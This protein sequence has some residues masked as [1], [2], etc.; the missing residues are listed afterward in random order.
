MPSGYQSPRAYNPSAN[1]FRQETEYH[2][3][4]SQPFPSPGY[5]SLDYNKTDEGENYDRMIAQDS[6]LKVRIRILRLF[7]RFLSVLLSAYT[8]ATMIQTL[9]K[10]YSTRHTL[11]EVSTPTGPVTRGPWALQTKTWPTYLLLVT[12]IITFFGSLIVVAFY[13]KGFK[14][15]NRAN[16]SVTYVTYVTFATHAT[17][18]I[19]TAAAYRAGKTGE[20]LWGW[21]CKGQNMVELRESFEG[22]LDFKKQCNVQGSSWAVSLAEAAAAVLTLLTLV[23]AYRRLA[24]QRRMGTAKEGRMSWMVWTKK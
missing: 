2:G 24:L 21:T 20:D 5:E 3:V 19:A 9:H 13:L 23:L 18:W 8:A 11:R 12:S 7:A 22:V 6:S 15:A 16:E 17:V 4:P 1:N 10:F 14:A